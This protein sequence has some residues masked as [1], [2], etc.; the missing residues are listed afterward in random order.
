VI[1]VPR[2]SLLAILAATLLT[3]STKP[4]HACKQPIP[5]GRVHVSFLAD[6]DL[7]SMV[8]WA[9]EHTCLEYTFDST[10]AGR[11]LAQGVIL[12]VVSHDV[13]TIFEL[14]L[15]T[16][17]L[18][19]KGTGPKR[20]IVSTG[21]ES[22]QSKTAREKEKADIERDRI[23]SNIEAEITKKDE[24]H[25]SI[26]RRGIDAA[27]GSFSV[28]TRSVRIVPEVKNGKPNGFRLNSIRPGSLL[29][30]VGFISGDLVQTVNGYDIS[31]PEKAL[32]VYAK[33]R[34]FSVVRVSLLRG[35]D[36]LTIE[37]TIE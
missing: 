17:N 31:T 21:P 36:P 37:T 18:R 33:V 3:F 24:N 34:A 12:T 13:G 6:S 14:L 5:G 25:Y 15:H 22:T 19:T 16:M 29:A 32:E 10:L 28:L 8:R 9:K 2:N 30:R 7:P 4:T 20:T 35:E 27:L 11:R 1:A 26:T 23:M